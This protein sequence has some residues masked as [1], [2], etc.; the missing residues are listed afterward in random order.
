M[1]VPAAFAQS[2]RKVLLDFLRQH[3]FALLVSQ[4]D[5]EPFATH[6]PLLVDEAPP[7]HGQLIG[8]MARANPQWKQLDGQDVLVV[9]SGPH[10]YVSPTWYEADN[11]VP[12]WNYLAVHAYGRCRLVDDDVELATILENYVTTYERAMPAPWQLDS[13]SE[14]VRKLALAVVGFRIELTR[15]EGKWK[16]GQNHPAERREK[17]AAH[18]AASSDAEAQAV[19]KLMRATIAAQGA[20]IAGDD[21]GPIVPTGSRRR[22]GPG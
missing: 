11:V 18:L 4:F 13:R 17:V 8:H 21:V 14:F 6:L 5:G 20:A 22:P 9:F 7:P 2:D 16:L 10:A 15:L 1:Y 19:A 12:T 3:S